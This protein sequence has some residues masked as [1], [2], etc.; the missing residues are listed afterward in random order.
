LF[1]L[2]RGTKVRPWRTTLKKHRTEIVLCIEEAHRRVA[3]PEPQAFDLVLG[4]HVRHTDLQHRGRAVCQ[5][6]GRNP[7]AAHFVTIEGRAYCEGPAL[8][9][10]P[11]GVR[12]AREPIRPLGRLPA[13]RRQSIWDHQRHGTHRLCGAR[14]SRLVIERLLLNG[15]DE[16]QFVAIQ[17]A[18][19]ELSGTVEHVLDILLEL[20]SFVC[21]SL[22][23]KRS[24]R[25]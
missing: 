11:N 2:W 7:R 17:V 19:A 12:E 9:Q 16:V 10:L 13:A 25:R 23:G 6:D 4:L 8:S 5:R 20:D 14:R 3:V 21:A 1:S 22:T 15:L 24:V 18:D